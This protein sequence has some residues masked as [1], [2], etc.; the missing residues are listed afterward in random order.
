LSSQPQALPDIRH[1]FDLYASLPEV[2]AAEVAPLYLRN[3]V[4]LT[5]KE[6]KQRAANA[7]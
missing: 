7:L 4:A 6:Q 3:N 5:L 2:S 1:A